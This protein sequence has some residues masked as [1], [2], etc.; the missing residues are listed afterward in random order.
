M[1]AAALA[2]L[3]RC[4]TF[5]APSGVVYALERQSLLVAAARD[6]LTKYARSDACAPVVLTLADGNRVTR[7][8]AI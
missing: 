2:M 1:S 7:A 4:C 6:P 8:C 5:S 3:A